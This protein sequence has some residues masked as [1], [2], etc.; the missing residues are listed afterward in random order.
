VFTRSGSTW[1]EQRELEGSGGFGSSVALSSDGN[2]ALIGAPG[3]GAV[4][5]FVRSGSTWTQQ[6]NELTGPGSFG[7]S[8]AL[9][10]DGNTALIGDPNDNPATESTGVGA[11]WVFTRLG[12]TWTQQG[13]KLTGG[14]EIGEGRFGL[15]V[16]LS[17]DGNTALIG[18]DYD[19]E[20]SRGFAAGAAWV[21]TRSGSTWTQQGG[22][23]T[24]G[25]ETG[26]GFFGVSVALSSDGNTALIGGPGE[27]AAWVFVR[28]ASTWTQQ[29]NKLTGG[30]EI[31]TGLGTHFGSSVALSSDAKTLL[32]GEPADPRASTAGVAR[33]FVPGHALSVAKTG[34]GSG[35]VTSAPTG[36][37]C[38]PTCSA[39]YAVGT[40]VKL[41]AKPAAGSVFSGWSGG[42]CSRKRTCTVTLS[43]DRS[44]TAKFTPKPPWFTKATIDRE[45]HAAT[46]G[47][48]AV[49]A[50]RIQCAMLTPG[51]RKE[52]PKPQF[53]RCRSPKTYKHLKNGKYTFEVRAVS[54]SG[55]GPA[56]KRRFTI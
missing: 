20:G 34:T 13:D 39:L 22:K 36:I 2:T 19:N 12:S 29:G 7:F 4:S 48:K 46:F 17:S 43:L 18:G 27:G 47:F 55:A 56:A 26:D 21:F 41:T 33:V 3:T 54:R 23:L 8:V 31:G 51:R 1:T 5:V 15:S 38:S 44:V 28:P 24:G 6:G 30:G 53:T 16:A 42:R 50:K 11:A 25:G 9:S 35:T 49:G 40:H 14:G 52:H 32:I 10:S 37:S 45:H